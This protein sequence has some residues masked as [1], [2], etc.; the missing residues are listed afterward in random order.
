[1]SL[2]PAA[3]G[4]KPLTQ[5]HLHVPQIQSRRAGA[6]WSLR[7]AGFNAQIHLTQ[8]AG[9]LLDLGA[10]ELGDDQTVAELRAS[11]SS[12][13]KKKLSDEAIGCRDSIFNLTYN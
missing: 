11:W 4:T 10:K 7:C 12:I 3:V 1:M 8:H 9:R 2:Q 6:M 13:A 5:H